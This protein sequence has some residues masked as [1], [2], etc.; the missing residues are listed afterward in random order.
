MYCL[1][2]VDN[3]EGKM[4]AGNFKKII[5]LACVIGYICA[6]GACQPRHIR[7]VPVVQKSGNSPVRTALEKTQKLSLFFGHQAGGD[8]IILGIKEVSA[9]VGLQS[10][11]FIKGRAN[12][13]G[14]TAGFYHAYIGADG[15]PQGK[16]KDF[17][18]IMHMGMAEKID[19][20]FMELDFA[21]INA[22]TDIKELFSLYQK[23]MANLKFE[24]PG[25]RF[26]HFTV[27]LVAEGSFDWIKKIIG[28][29]TDAR[30]GNIKREEYNA[31]LRAEYPA[32]ET[33]FDLAMMETYST[34][35]DFALK[36]YK[37]QTYYLLQDEYTDDGGNLNK[38]GQINIAGQ[39]I[40]ALAAF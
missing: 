38:K 10:P 37:K 21:D 19:I 3:Q 32:K 20:S 6:T 17:E 33:L 34:S 25:V 30:E 13:P 7:R 8:A 40:F 11:D 29:K 36:K 35:G 26:I 9:A 5:C 39:L 4:V 2:L 23:T 15:D 1:L 24:F 27:P 16:I 28:Q 12:P 22:D 14:K 18:T 31:L